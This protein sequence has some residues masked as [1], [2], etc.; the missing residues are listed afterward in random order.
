MVD[1]LLDPLAEGCDARVVN[2]LLKKWTV[3]EPPS[4]E[5]IKRALEENEFPLV[6]GRLASFVFYG[7]AD[8]LRLRHWIFGL[9]S[10][11]PFHRIEGT[12]ID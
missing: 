5:A 1:R 3:G 6:D 4:D 12:E 9:P 2:P 8:E 7:R 11:Q 10:S